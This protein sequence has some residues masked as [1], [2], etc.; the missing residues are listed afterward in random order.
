MP[1][2]PSVRV[3]TYRGLVLRA[4]GDPPAARAAHAEALR[5]DPDNL[6]ARSCPGQGLAE[7]GDM[8]RA[9]LQLSGIR[10]RGE[11]RTRAEVALHR[12]IEPGH[13][14]SREAVRR[15][16]FVKDVAVARP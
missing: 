15:E 6:M 13:G 14:V 7:A 10:A 8:A 16:P 3:L 2:G 5:L 4:G 9:R 11:R 1:E 12:S